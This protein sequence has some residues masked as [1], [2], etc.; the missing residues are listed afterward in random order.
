[1]K[2]ISLP[3]PGKAPRGKGGSNRT[4][5]GPGVG[6]AVTADNTRGTNATAPAGG[7]AHKS[8]GGGKRKG[9]YPKASTSFPTLGDNPPTTSPGKW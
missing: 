6:K 4:L 3:A 8:M 9:F 1:M 7:K 2:S 5:D